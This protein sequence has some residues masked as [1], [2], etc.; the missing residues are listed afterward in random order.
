M[1]AANFVFWYVAKCDLPIPPFIKEVVHSDEPEDFL[2]NLCTT[3]PTPIP[4]TA[5]PKISVG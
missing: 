5:P 4:K 3:N 1:F 2:K